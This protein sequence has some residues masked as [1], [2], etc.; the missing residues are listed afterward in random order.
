[1][2]KSKRNKSDE[3]LELRPFNIEHICSSLFL[4]LIF[5]IEI[6]ETS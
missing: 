5:F 2:Q 3:L 4:R 6:N 1:L